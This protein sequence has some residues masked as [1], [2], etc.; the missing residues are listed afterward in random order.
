MSH[1]KFLLSIVVMEQNSYKAAELSLIV[2]KM[3][4]MIKTSLSFY[5]ICASLPLS[6]QDLLSKYISQQFGQTNVDKVGDF[7]H[8]FKI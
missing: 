6:G 2:E 7:T 1:V 4:V 5:K 3:A 8:T